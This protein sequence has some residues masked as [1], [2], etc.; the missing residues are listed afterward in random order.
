MAVDSRS[1]VRATSP[2]ST[3][4]TSTYQLAS[5]SADERSIRDFHRYKVR[6][7]PSRF[8]T[9]AYVPMS[10]TYNWQEGTSSASDS[11]IDLSYAFMVVNS[12]MQ[13]RREELGTLNMSH[14]AIHQSVE[15]LTYNSTVTGRNRVRNRFI[16]MAASTALLQA[17]R[18]RTL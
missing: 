1:H 5:M 17:A 3:K 7:A 6:K 18:L 11:L 13:S 15:Y 10:Q 16:K 9:E 2:K 4:Q 12:N 8:Y 14:E